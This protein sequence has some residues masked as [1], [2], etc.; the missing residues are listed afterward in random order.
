MQELINSGGLP[1]SEDP[2]ERRQEMD[3]KDLENRFTYHPPKGNQAERYTEIRNRV[4]TLAEFLNSELPECREKAL[5][6]THLEEA[7]FW[8]NAS[9]ARNE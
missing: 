8:C 9:I 2:P 4:K 1:Q 6:F 5:A 3:A 7:V